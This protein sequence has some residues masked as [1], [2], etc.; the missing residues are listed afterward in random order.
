MD[1]NKAVNK[2]QASRKHLRRWSNNTCCR[3]CTL[4]YTQLKQRHTAKAKKTKQQ[5][6]KNDLADN[7]NSK[8]LRRRF[9]YVWPATFLAHRLSSSSLA[10]AHDIAKAAS[11]RR[12]QTHIA[13]VCAQVGADQGFGDE[14][15]PQRVHQ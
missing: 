6:K 8:R 14:S 12:T 11:T 9:R 1:N 15:A 5:P 3:Y 10:C 7:N 4:S 13:I 2:Q